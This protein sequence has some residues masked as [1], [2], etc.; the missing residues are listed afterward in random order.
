LSPG[1]VSH[2]RSLGFSRG[3]PPTFNPNFSTKESGM[4]EKHLKEIFNILILEGNTN[5]N[6]PEILLSTT[7]NS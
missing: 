7:E 5:Q 6:N 3:F 1:S 4:A 2:P